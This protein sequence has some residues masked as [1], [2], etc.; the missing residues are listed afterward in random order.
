[1]AWKDMGSDAHAYRRDN[2]LIRHGLSLAELTGWPTEPRPKLVKGLAVHFWW[3]WAW[4][5]LDNVL[6]REPNMS[7]N[8][9]EAAVAI[10]RAARL[11]QELCWGKRDTWTFQANLLLLL[12]CSV[13]TEEHCSP[14]GRNEIW[15]RA[16]PFFIVPRTFFCL[17]KRSEER[18]QAYIN[19][20]GLAHDIHDVLAD[21]RLGI[22]SLPS[23]WFA[24]ID[25]NQGFRRDVVSEWFDRAE[26]ELA[27]VIREAR[28]LSVSRELRIVNFM[29]NEPEE[30]RKSLGPYSRSTK[31]DA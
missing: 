21:V 23:S 2:Y 3:A 14:L 31:D 9:G 26:R 11:Q 13:A 5:H 27:E 24:E 10:C 20:E 28:A 8:V 16:S 4:R 15:K 30:L 6:D 29:I 7:Y 19:A 17:D 22:R 25:P 18:Y 12:L 1:M